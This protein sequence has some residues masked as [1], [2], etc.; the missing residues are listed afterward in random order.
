MTAR[1]RDLLTRAK[2]E[3]RAA[4]H[5][6]APREAHLLMAHA[7]GRSEAEVLARDDEEAPPEPA[8]R[9][10][11]LLRRRLAGE[12]V[13]YLTGRREFF[14]RSFRVDSRV[15]I[16]RPE[17][18]H[19]I[20]AALELE[21]P[22]RSTILDLGTGSGCLAVT[23]ALELP[24][25][26]VV[27]TDASPAAL[28]LARANARQLGTTE[29]VACLAARWAEGVRLEGVDLVVSNPPYIGHAEAP[30]L[31]PEITRF[32]PHGALFAHADGL[33]AYRELYA[34]L[35]GLRPGTPVLCEIGLGQE[36]AVRELA[37]AAGFAHQ[38]TRTD[39][40]GIPRVVVVNRGRGR[41]G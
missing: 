6:P 22:E 34:S 41:R 35:D 31:S 8:G 18:E 39:Y 10:D 38:R 2:A 19:L 4:A 30:G 3:L 14:G 11:E 32:E 27:A 20:E 5:A 23:L 9:F 17:S 24:G 28:A 29:R 21:L 13:A 7:L 36:T 33:A 16:P 40:A 25:A 1:I 15:L 12:P 26:R 37:A